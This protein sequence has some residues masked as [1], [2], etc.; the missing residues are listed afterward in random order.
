MDLQGQH[1]SDLEAV[2]R[3]FLNSGMKA[4]QIRGL[5]EVLRDMLEQIAKENMLPIEVLER[6]NVIYFRRTDG[7][8]SDPSF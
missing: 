6:R 3:N 8:E 2:L 1:T 4:A 7:G 5:T